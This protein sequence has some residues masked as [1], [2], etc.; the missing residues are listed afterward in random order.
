MKRKVYWYEIIYED[1]NGEEFVEVYDTLEETN[2]RLKEIY[3]EGYVNVDVLLVLDEDD[4]TR[5][6]WCNLKEGELVK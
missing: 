1:Q 3:N 6:M 2:L 5:N 4:V